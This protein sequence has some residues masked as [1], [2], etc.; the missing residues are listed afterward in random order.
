MTA[1][2]H[3]AGLGTAVPARTG[4]LRP[5]GQ[6]REALIPGSRAGCRATWT[7][8]PR[9][10]RATGRLTMELA[11]RGQHVVAVEPALPMRRI[12]RRKLAAAGQWNRVS[13]GPRV[14]RPAA[15]A[16]RFACLVVACSAF[17][18]SPGHAGEA[19]GR[20]WSGC[21][22]WGGCVAHLAERP[23]PARRPRLPARQFPGRCPWSWAAM[24]RRWSWP[25][26]STPRWSARY[27]DVAGDASPSRCWAQSAA[28]P[29]LQGLEGR[30]KIAVLAPLVTAI[31]G[32]SAAVR[33]RSCLTWPRPGRPGHQ[34]HVTPP[35]AWRSGGR[36]DRPESIPGPRGQRSTGRPG[37]PRGRSGG[38]RRGRGRVRVHHG[39]CGHLGDPVR[40]GPQSRL[41]RARRHARDGAARTG[42]AHPPPASGPGGVGG[43]PAGSQARRAARRGRRPGFSGQGLAPG[44]PGP[45]D[46]AA[47]PAGWRYPLVGNCRAGR[48]VPG[49]LSPEKGAAEAIDIARAAEVPIDVY[50]DVT[51]PGIAGNGRPAARLA[52]VTVH[53][54]VPRASLWQAMARA[55]VASYPARWDEPFGLAA[56]EAQAC[57]TP[58]AAFR[59]GGLS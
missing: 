11:E 9:S 13:G 42:R 52:R 49:P 38:R 16:R 22:C 17:T 29:G 7:G 6:R 44:R 59:R 10:A 54:G 55:A 32:R 5:A 26:S 41:R 56:A 24:T 40:R 53:Q 4:A 31:R 19:G 36:G 35:P 45:R 18:P 25:R 12:L 34:V 50:G 15:A 1:N 3:G 14:L 33:R 2:R 20:R 58:V 39:L 51:M 37:H 43:A 48:A 47:V 8:S 27:G 57:G 30:N 46:P 21:A 23:G 28:R